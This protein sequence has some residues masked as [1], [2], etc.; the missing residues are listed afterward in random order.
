M[1]PGWK[2]MIWVLW[3]GISEARSWKRRVEVSFERV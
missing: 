1:S 2:E 3:A